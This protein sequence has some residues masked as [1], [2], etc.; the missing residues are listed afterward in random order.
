MLSGT[1]QQVELLRISCRELQRLPVPTTLKQTLHL[2]RSPEAAAMRTE[3]ARWSQE[4]TAGNTEAAALVLPDVADAQRQ[5]SFAKS[6]SRGGALVT[7]IGVPVSIAGLVVA[8]PALA[9]AGVA[10][11]VAGGLALGSQKLLEHFGRWAMYG[12]G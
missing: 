9:A 8:A 2:V 3:L 7:C 12:D 4:L 10:V 5:L 6:S 1:S 11:S